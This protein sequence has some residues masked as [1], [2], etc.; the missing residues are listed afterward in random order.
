MYSVHDDPC[1]HRPGFPIRTSA[2]QGSF[3]SSPRLFAAFHVLHRQQIPRHPPKALNY[4]SH[5]IPNCLQLFTGH[6]DQKIAEFL[7]IFECQR[8]CEFYSTRLRNQRWI[9][10]AQTC[11]VITPSNRFEGFMTFIIL[12]TCQRPLGHFRD[13]VED[14]GL[15][16]M[17]YGLQ[18]RCSPN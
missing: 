1:R 2:D 5:R 15:E 9:W 12:C 13:P 14:I 8:R 7:H 17:T 10:F 6:D 3:G 16:P 4:L 18:S 11:E